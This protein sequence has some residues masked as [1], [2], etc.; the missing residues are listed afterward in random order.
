MQGQEAQEVPQGVLG[1]RSEEL[2]LQV[3]QVEPEPGQVAQGQQELQLATGGVGEEER[4]Q[5]ELRQGEREWQG[6]Q[7]PQEQQ[8]QRRAERGA[9]R[10]GQLV[11]QA[12]VV[13]RELELE[14]QEPQGVV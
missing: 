14:V 1:L 5:Q 6:Q 2:G 11:L 8:G 13:L 7:G 10:V 4:G 3:Q 12:E 9:R